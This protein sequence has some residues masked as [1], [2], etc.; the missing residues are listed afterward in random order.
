MQCRKCISIISLIGLIGCAKSE[1]LDEDEL[2]YVKTTIAITNA[3]VASRDS[4]QFTAKL[5]SVYKKLGTTKDDYIKETTNF[6]QQPDRAGI[7]FRAIA[8]SLNVK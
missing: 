6:A 1:K 7:V 2:R 4:A 3:R 8:D 5:D